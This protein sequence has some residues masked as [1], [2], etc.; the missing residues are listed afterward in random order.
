MTTKVQSRSIGSESSCD[1][2]LDHR[3]I[4]GFHASLDLA[5]NGLLSL[6]DKDSVNGTFLNRSDTWIR[7][8]RITLCIGDRVRLGELEVPLQQLTAVFGQHLNAR[9]ESRHFALTGV[10]KPIRPFADLPA[11]APTL[12][13]PV[14]NPL[15]GK[16]E[17]RE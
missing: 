4:S 8:K 6:T 3:D 1:L 14:R 11:S 13:K 15:T 16:I 12:A 9:L 2:V 17:E 7:V 5:K 10:N